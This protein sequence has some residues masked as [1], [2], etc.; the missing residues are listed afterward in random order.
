MG[1]GAM[2]KVGRASAEVGWMTL[3]DIWSS[4]PD[5]FAPFG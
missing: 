3:Q 1:E 2:G 5:F 4:I